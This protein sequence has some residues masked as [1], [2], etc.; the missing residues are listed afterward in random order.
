MTTVQ[1]PVNGCLYRHHRC[2]ILGGRRGCVRSHLPDVQECVSPMFVTDVPGCTS[3]Q[4][5][6][7]REHDRHVVLLV[8]DIFH[9]S[10]D[11]FRN[12]LL[13]EKQTLLIIGG[14]SSVVFGGEFNLQE[15]FSPPPHCLVS[16]SNL[17]IRCHLHFLLRRCQQQLCVVEHTRGKNVLTD[18]KS[19][20]IKPSRR[21][22]L[23]TRRKVL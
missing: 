14:L 11:V 13:A 6:V 4:S 8:C 20:R 16:I 22:C 3:D 19:V 17:L 5:S 15:Y 7:D 12:K 1:P 9:S 21:L 23:L 2:R 18:P 10:A